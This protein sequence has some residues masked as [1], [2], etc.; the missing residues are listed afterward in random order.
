MCVNTCLA[1][2]GP[3]AVYEQ[4]P[5]CGE[6]R[7][8]A[9][10]LAH[11]KEVARRTFQTYP[12]G[13]QL[14]AMWA[15]TEN[16]R[17]MKHRAQETTRILAQGRQNPQTVPDYDDVY[18]GQAYLDA[19]QDEA[20]PIRNDEMV[21]MFSIDGAQ[22]YESKASDCW[23]YVWVLFDLPPDARYKKRYVLPGAVIGGPKKPKNIDS[24]IFPGL[25]HV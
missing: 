21:L 1:Y 22:L 16:A 14:Q 9:W 12:L 15:S 20:N 19:V 3:F 2:V 8:D 17:L 23:F 5:Y 25:Y 4:C 11:S 7:Y 13:P 6:P 24:F 18:Y 10:T